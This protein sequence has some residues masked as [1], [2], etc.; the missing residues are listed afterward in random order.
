VNLREW[1]IK[2]QSHRKQVAISGIGIRT[3]LFSA[4]AFVVCPQLG[5]G[6]DWLVNH[7]PLVVFE[8]LGHHG[9]LLACGAFYTAF[10]WS[11][12]E[13]S[14]P[15]V[16]KPFLNQHRSKFILGLSLTTAL[17]LAILQMRAG[18]GLMDWAVW[19]IGL[20]VLSFGLASL[21]TQRIRKLSRN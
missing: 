14:T 9:C 2:E 3:L 8:K 5:W 20:G 17:T 15:R 21:K 6:P 7:G 12:V 4:L 11:G 1:L 16:W 10:V 18:E 19:L 13:M